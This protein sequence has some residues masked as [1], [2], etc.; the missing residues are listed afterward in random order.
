MTKTILQGTVRGAKKT[1]TTDEEV[2]GQH[3][4]VDRPGLLR[5]TVSCK[6]IGGAPMTLRVTSLYVYFKCSVLIDSII[7]YE[8]NVLYCPLSEINPYYCYYYHY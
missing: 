2:G 8:Q 1:R 6:V 5:D 3:Q 7:F 4:R